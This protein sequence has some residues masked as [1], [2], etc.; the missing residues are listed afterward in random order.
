MA[1]K[2]K[3]ILLGKYCLL[4]LFTFLCFSQSFGQTAPANSDKTGYPYPSRYANP[5]R[6][7][8]KTDT[9]NKTDTTKIEPYIQRNYKRS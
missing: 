1:I 3:H 2:T 7:S 9:T 4:I 8:F 5:N 6:Y